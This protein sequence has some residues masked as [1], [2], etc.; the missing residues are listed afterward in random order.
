M[1]H[2]RALR[3]CVRAAQGTLILSTGGGFDAFFGWLAR[4]IAA[5]ADV[6]LRGPVPG[7]DPAP[8]LSAEVLRRLESPALD[9]CWETEETLGWAYQLWNAPRRQAAFA[10]LYGQREKIGAADLPAATQL[11]TP[12]WIAAFLVENTLGRLWLEMHPD[13]RLGEEMQYLLPFSGGQALPPR[14]LAQ[15]RLLDPA[16]GTMHFGLAAL[17]LLVSMYLEEA[18]RAGQPGWP[19]HPGLLPGEHPAAAA[20][21]NNL[22]GIEIDPQALRLAQAALAIRAARCGAAW[23]RLPAANLRLLPAPFG[24]LLPEAAEQTFDC[25]L[26][27]PPYMVARNLPPDLAAFI[28]QN[29]PAGRRDLYAAFILRVLQQTATGGRAGLLTQQSFLHLRGFAELRACLSAESMLETLV[30]IGPGAFPGAVGEKA[31]PAAFI[32]RRADSSP[33][34]PGGAR[35]V[36]IRLERIKGSAAR[37][38][39]LQRAL[40]HLRSGAGSN[41]QVT[42]AAQPADA[43]ANGQPWVFW[44][45]PGIL[46]VLRELPSLAGVPGTD[47]NKT[48]ANARFIRRLSDLPPGALESGRWRLLARPARQMPY[49]R[50]FEQAVDWS[51]EAREFYRDNPASNPLAAALID[52]PGICWSRIATR[53]FN[54]RRFPA[55]VIPDV[56]TPAIYPP[57]EDS[58]FLLALLNSRPARCLLRVLNPTI[59]YALGD[60][61]RLPLPAADPAQ[62]AALGG[63]ALQ[64][65]TAACQG[66]SPALAAIQV[67][68]DRRVVALYGF[69]EEEIIFIESEVPA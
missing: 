54:A 58:A 56:S 32:L 46:R 12:G 20:L 33:P 45:P 47:G 14:P 2:L 34:A 66:D 42:L 64:A 15:I 25:V 19:V 38:A 26:A 39:A 35:V 21:R 51:A 65:E 7:F 59:N 57:E 16:C 36:C 60:V 41:A 61:R 23:N 52:R 68:I 53:R 28:R 62:K 4:R 63:L 3:E 37:H 17:P 18:G 13:S 6:E 40:G 29:Y 31:N 69:S 5:Q 30:Q 10:R 43:G 50:E 11:F 55:G 48:G 9:P 24:S 44:A 22:F 1:K 67:E 8:A 27:N 49:C